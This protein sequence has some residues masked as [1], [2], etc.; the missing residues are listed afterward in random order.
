MND[1]ERQE[2][3]KE[4]RIREINNDV[5]G[6]E[7][8]EISQQADLNNLKLLLDRGVLTQDEYDDKIRYLSNSNDQRYKGLTYS[9]QAVGKMQTL[10]EL[11]SIK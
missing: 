2:N 1:K 8:S 4:G 5:K 9:V 11:I 7:N 3:K 10:F 6:E